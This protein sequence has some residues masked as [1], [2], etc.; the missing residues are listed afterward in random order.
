LKKPANPPNV[1]IIISDLLE[2]KE[3]S[4]YI[5]DAKGRY[6]HWDKLR[7]LPPPE[8]LSSEQWWANIKYSRRSMYKNININDQNGKPFVFLYSDQIMKDLHWL[9][10]NASGMLGSNQPIVNSQMKNT[11]LIRS[12]IEESINS[13]QLEG[14]STTW[15]VAKEMLIKKRKPSDKNEQMIYNNYIAMQFIREYKQEKLTQNLILELQKILTENTLEDKGHSG[16]FRTTAEN[17]NVVNYKGDILHVPPSAESLPKRMEDLYI[18]ENENNS[19]IFIHPVIKS[20]ILHFLLGYEHPF[21]DGNGR[22]A[23]ALFYWSMAKQ[24]YWLIE[25]ISISKIIKQAPV[26]YGRAY[27]YTETDEND[28]TYF[29]EYH[30]KIIKQAINDLYSYIDKKIKEIYHTESL[31]STTK[32]LSGKLNYRQLALIKHAIKHPNYI[33]TIT[34]HQNSHDIAYDTARLDLSQLSDTFNF[35]NKE[36]KGKGFIFKSPSDLSFRIQNKVPK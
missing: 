25:Y 31:L 26:K 4:N 33:Y 30:L 15:I 10:Q 6:L 9:D 8:R 11:Y 35:L 3:V 28:I 29:I 13:S 23:R 16:Y 20:I 18:F 12:L 24:N 21:V 17:V 22:T 7:F 27:L 1:D 2:K 36:K 19:D 34:E 14:A 32:E 5:T